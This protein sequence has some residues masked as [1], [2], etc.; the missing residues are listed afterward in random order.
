LAT[1][2]ADVIRE[3]NQR[4][5][6]QLALT[7]TLFEGDVRHGEAKQIVGPWWAVWPPLIAVLLALLYRQVVLALGAA[8][9]VGAALA[10]GF[11][12]VDAT[13]VAVRDHIG[14]AFTSE[15]KLYVLAF[16]LALIGMVNVT[17]RSGGNQGL[18]DAMARWARSARSTRVVTAMMGL[19]VFFDDYANALIVGSSA[20]SLTD[21][22]RI[23]REKLAYLVDS[24][25]APVAGLALISTWVGYEVGLFDSLASELSLQQSGFEIFLGIL[26]SRFYC[27]FAL[28]FVFTGA[29]SGRDFGP[30]LAAER[31]AHTLGHLTRPNAQ[32]SAD[33]AALEY[34]APARRYNPGLP[35]LTIVIPAITG[36][37]ISR[38]AAPAPTAQPPPHPPHAQIPPDPAA[39]E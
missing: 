14:S 5:A 35:I 24:T 32:I 2:K 20:R 4:L 15:F 17:G 8:V 13:V 27:L 1:L 33:P 30:M 37:P 23:S 34:A 21:K 9:W 11:N 3:D 22:M 29:L 19:V 39:L 26:P 7:P 25:A 10:H 36:I 31:R 16:T 6:L 38:N 28:A 12:P 18:V